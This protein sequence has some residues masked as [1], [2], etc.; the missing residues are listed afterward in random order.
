MRF[1]PDLLSVNESVVVELHPHWS[2]LV[3]PALTALVV[4]GGGVA[5]VFAFPSMPIVL[6]GLLGI[7]M[8]L[9]AGWFV[10]RVAERSAAVFVVT[11]ERVAL[12]TGLIVKKGWDVRLERVTDVSFDQSLI[13]RLLRTGDIWVDSGGEDGK[14]GMARIPHPQ[15]VK[16]LIFD[17]IDALS[18]ARAGGPSS[19]AA[20]VG[21]T[22]HAGLSVAEQIE[23]LDELRRRGVI[24][25]E[26]FAAEKSRLIGI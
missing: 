12:T 24:S 20:S 15:A 2:S 21:Q 4:D 8:A 25:D 11:T 17:Q 26:E 7:V 22:V 16:T 6:A 3:K 1:P 10:L 9:A 19:S 5:L 23:K 13:D 14:K 18:G